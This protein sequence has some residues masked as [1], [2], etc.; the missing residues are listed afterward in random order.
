[1]CSAQAKF[2]LQSNRAIRRV[3]SDEFLLKAKH[4]CT[5]IVKHSFPSS[6]LSIVSLILSVRIRASAGL[7]E[8]HKFSSKDSKTK[9]FHTIYCSSA[10]S[11]VP[12]YETCSENSNNTAHGTAQ[13]GNSDKMR[14]SWHV[15]RN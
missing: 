6:L 11:K 9:R 15:F 7:I 14:L 3:I 2:R 4:Y 5:H 10:V 1:M 13:H 8:V 12:V